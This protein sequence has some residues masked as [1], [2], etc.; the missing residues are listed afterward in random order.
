MSHILYLI[1]N[2][3]KSIALFT[4][5]FLVIFFELFSIHYNYSGT[6]ATINGQDTVS[7]SFYPYPYYSDE[8]V[9]VSLT[10][11]AIQHHAVPMINPFD[12]NKPFAN[13]LV[14]FYSLT[15]LLFFIFG[16]NPLTGWALFAL[17]NGLIICILTYLISRKLGGSVF[18]SG[19]AML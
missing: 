17:I 11:Y 2:N 8:W 19:I 5:T 12:N 10:E 15:A 16:I 1:T 6:V 13:P 14:V 7:H 4:I 18:A 9:G 3:K